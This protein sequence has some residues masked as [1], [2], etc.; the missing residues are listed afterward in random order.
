MRLFTGYF[1]VYLT[2]IGWLF[3]NDSSLA[4]EITLDEVY[5]QA[6]QINEEVEI[7]K[8]HF[9]ITQKTEVVAL[10]NVVFPRHLWQKT[11]EILFK[12]SILRRKFNLVVLAVPSYEP[13]N[14]I[15]PLAIYEQEQRILTEFSLLKRY[16]G[17][18]IIPSD[19]GTFTY[20]TVMDIFNLLNHSSQQIDLINKG[21]LSPSVLFSQAMRVHEDIVL[22][23]NTLEIKNKTTPPAKNLE[24]TP[25]DVLQTALQLLREI[26]R[27]Q[28]LA[29]FETLDTYALTAETTVTSNI[30]F[31]FTG[32]ILAELQTLK[33]FLHLR[34]A[35][36]VN[37]NLYEDKSPADV[38]QIL[39][40]SL[41]QLRL[42]YALN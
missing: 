14:T 4:Y 24:A 42:I 13:S 28:K 27:L 33:A 21:E 15:T 18:Q 35:A 16:L 8:Q 23:L 17:I 7:V 12:L 34:Y 19:K 30:L 29:G 26:K 40:W 38:Q 39:G 37:S 9:N 20:K 32:I 6:V 11:Y 31:H 22:I 36:T 10:Q 2:L 1:G 5:Q 25:T 3:G 41:K